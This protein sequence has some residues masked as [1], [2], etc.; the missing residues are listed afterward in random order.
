MTETEKGSK[1]KTKIDILSKNDQ[2]ELCPLYSKI[3]KSCIKFLTSMTDP[4]FLSI[5]MREGRNVT[6][7]QQVHLGST[8]NEKQTDKLEELYKDVVDK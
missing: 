5:F 4:I 6:N 3:K 8:S 2:I 7:R 1:I